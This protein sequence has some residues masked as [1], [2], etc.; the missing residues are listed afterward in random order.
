MTSAERR[1][2]PLQVQDQAL[3]TLVSDRRCGSESARRHKAKPIFADLAAWLYLQ[4]PKIS[5]KTPLAAAIRY[6]PIRIK[7]LRPYL[8]HGI[9]E[10]DNNTAE[11]SMRRNRR[12]VL[13]A[14]GT[15]LT[16]E[17]RLRP[18]S[19]S[20]LKFKDSARIIDLLVVLMTPTFA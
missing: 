9:L 1:L 6:A 8:D 19:C 15:N 10:L 4:L 13:A 17:S 16:F 11:R 12:S 7:R 2:V 14:G 18:G 20:N 5:G 3:L